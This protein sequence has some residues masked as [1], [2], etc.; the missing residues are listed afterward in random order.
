MEKTL[1]ESRKK[2]IYEFICSDLYVPMK[3][4]EMAVLMDV[5]R[6]DRGDLQQV[7][8]ELVEEGKIGGS[9]YE[10]Y[11]LLYQELKEKRRY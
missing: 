10:D 11:R 1:L 9:R 8:S 6:E 4:K 3:V 2:M 5:P 7:L